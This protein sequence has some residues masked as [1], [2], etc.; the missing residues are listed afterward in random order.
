MRIRYVIGVLMF[1]AGFSVRLTCVRQ[2][3]GI[4]AVAADKALSPQPLD[5]RHDRE[6]GAPPHTAESMDSRT[7]A[8]I[9]SEGVSSTSATSEISRS[10]KQFLKDWLLAHRPHSPSG[11][12]LKVL[13]RLEE[14]SAE[15]VDSF[16]T[17]YKERR[18]RPNGAGTNEATDILSL[19]LAVGGV[20]ASDFITAR[21]LDSQIDESER[22][23]L[24]MG[25][26]P[27]SGWR[28]N[29]ATLSV[30]E[31]LFQIARGLMASTILLDR[32]AG[33]GILGAT[34]RED[35][36]AELRRLL[37]TESNLQLTAAAAR[38]L[39]RCGIEADI[40][41]LESYLNSIERN[42]SKTDLADLRDHIEIALMDLRRRLN[43]GD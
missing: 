12:R 34:S 26:N 17:E 14:V 37:Q 10:S 3:P 4:K 40:P 29:Y 27:T 18:Q 41:L 13:G 43:R 39:G 24:L 38:S 42:S 25:L 9:S 19:I 11:F 35:A 36:R 33:V 1:F 7:Y 23:N 8:T 2:D 32:K 15:M 20:A 22:N 28:C 31:E 30:S 6:S 21:L 16:I 5:V